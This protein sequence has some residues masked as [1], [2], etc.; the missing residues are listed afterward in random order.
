MTKN[1]L[2]RCAE[3]YINGLGAFLFGRKNYIKGGKEFDK[4]A[5]KVSQQ[6][7]YDYVLTGI[8]FREIAIRHMNDEYLVQFA[9]RAPKYCDEPAHNS[10]GILAKGEAHKESYEVQAIEQISSSAS[11]AN[12]YLLFRRNK[13]LFNHYSGTGQGGSSYGQKKVD[14]L[15]ERMTEEAAELVVREMLRQGEVVEPTD[16]LETKIQDKKLREEFGFNLTRDQ[17]FA[18]FEQHET[19]EVARKV[20]PLCDE[21]Q[22]HYIIREKNMNRPVKKAALERCTDQQFLMDFVMGKIIDYSFGLDVACAV[23]PHINSIEFLEWLDSQ[24]CHGYSGGHVKERYMFRNSLDY[25]RVKQLIR[26]QISRLQKS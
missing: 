7:L 20:I 24:V 6:E 19:A 26:D 21:E 11:L 23:I 4:L 8:Y 17:W 2:E 5:E 14:K 16:F 22:L 18:Y 12:L 1:R 15:N 13:I 25:S 9:C 3:Y 10:S